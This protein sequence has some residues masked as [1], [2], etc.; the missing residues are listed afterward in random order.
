MG[1]T[2]KVYEVNRAGTT[3]RVL[4]Q[5]AEVVPVKTVESTHAFPDCECPRHRPPGSD[6]AYKTWLGH[7][8]QCAA[9]RAGAVC[10][11]ATRL[12]RAWRQGRA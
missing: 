10:V 11:T 3:I 12:G 4:R 9:C 1:M 8:T 5:Q 2:I 7:T 6:A